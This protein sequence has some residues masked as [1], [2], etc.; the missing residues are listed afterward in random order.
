LLELA[1]YQSSLG[2]AYLLRQQSKNADRIFN[3][4]LAS[5]E[6]A[7]ELTGDNV[8]TLFTLGQLQYTIAEQLADI[9]RNDEALAMLDAAEASLEKLISLSPKFG[10]AYLSLWNVFIERSSCLA[11]ENLLVDSIVELDRIA[12]M[13]S[14]MQELAEAPWMRAGAQAVTTLGRSLRWGRLKQIRDG[15]LNTLTAAAK[16]ELAGEQARRLPE[17]TREAGDHY[18][19]ARAL[20]YAA[21]AANV[22]ERIADDERPAVFEPLAADA[23]KQLALAWEKG[24]LRRRSGMLSG[25]I[26]GG[27]ELAELKEVFEFAILQDREDY[28]KLLQRVE[29]EKRPKG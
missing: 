9:S 5:L 26:R 4:A 24:Y 27:V 7:G 11:A 25:L 2:E 29:T 23:V 12:A 1:R 16:Y 20:A 15:G 3:A 17:I 18:V 28:R 13:N 10:E 21:T 8:D 19:A 22:D 14:K 6:T